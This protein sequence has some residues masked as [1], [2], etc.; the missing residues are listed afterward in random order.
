MLT[1]LT[2]EDGTLFSV[3]TQG[4][5]TDAFDRVVRDIEGSVDSEAALGDI[6]R[7]WPLPA[8]SPLIRFP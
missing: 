2:T 1:G 4:A 6:V 3:Y 7:H 5:A 8:F